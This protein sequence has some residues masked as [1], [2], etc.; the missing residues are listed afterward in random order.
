MTNPN[1]L[2]QLCAEKM[3]WERYGFPVTNVIGEVANHQGWVRRENKNNKLIPVLRESDLPQFCSDH[4]AAITLLDAL[5]KE[6]WR[7]CFNQGTDGTWEGF[8]TK[9]EEFGVIPV[10][11][12]H[13]GASDTMALAIVEVF[14][15]VHGIWEE[16]L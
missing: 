2:N 5:A 8:V 7:A 6:G 12:D 9:R 4:N 13:Y 15:R 10:E 3:G 14:L 16:E 1:K 11:G